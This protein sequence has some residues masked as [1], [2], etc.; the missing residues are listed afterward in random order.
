MRNKTICED[1]AYMPITNDCSRLFLN[2][3]CWRFLGELDKKHWDAV[4]NELCEYSLDDE[5]YIFKQV[6]HYG[7][8]DDS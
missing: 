1:L 3:M 4:H 7:N 5:L 8:G 6:I 2:I